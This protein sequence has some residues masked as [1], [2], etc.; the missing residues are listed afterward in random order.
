MSPPWDSWYY[1]VLNTGT[2]IV[3]CPHNQ[4]S[5]TVTGGNNVSHAIRG[6]YLLILYCDTCYHG[7]QYLF[8]DYTGQMG[9]SPHKTINGHKCN[10]RN[11]NIQKSVKEHF[12]FPRISESLHSLTKKLQMEIPVSDGWNLNVS[13]DLILFVQAW[14]RLKNVLSLHGESISLKRLE[15]CYHYLLPMWMA[16]TLILNRIYLNLLCKGHKL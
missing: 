16:P 9:H 5:N 15:R 4:S 6:L 2:E 12:S 11:S 1:K 3:L 14:I 8:A 7:L 10:N 13:R